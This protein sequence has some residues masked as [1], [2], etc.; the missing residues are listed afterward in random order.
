MDRPIHV[1]LCRECMEA[2]H[3]ATG[4]PSGEPLYLQRPE[5]MRVWCEG[6]TEDVAPPA[7]PLPTSP[8]CPPPKGYEY[9]GEYRLWKA[10]EP[11]LA[12]WN[13]ADTKSWRAH[14]I[15]CC[16]VARFKFDARDDPTNYRWI[17]RPAPLVRT[18]QGT[19]MTEIRP[20]DLNTD[21]KHGTP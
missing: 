4:T 9:T 6:A 10:N 3:R 19:S 17:L 1:N 20:Q 16:A 11:F 7:P 8:P 5:L 18:G 14:A 12:D 13:H 21:E 15:R 2:L